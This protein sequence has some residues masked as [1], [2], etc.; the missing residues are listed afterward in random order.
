MA[1]SV[2]PQ[3]LRVLLDS[4]QKLVLLDVR[5]KNDLEAAPKKL[6]ALPG[7]IRKRLMNGALIFPRTGRLSRT[8]SRGVL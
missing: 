8:V 6:A 7:L 4:D 1:D 2:P 5:R 3:E